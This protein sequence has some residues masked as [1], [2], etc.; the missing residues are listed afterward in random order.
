M[1]KILSPNS[2]RSNRLSQQKENADMSSRSK[3]EETRNKVRE[4]LRTAV[5]ESP[6]EYPISYMELQRQTGIDRRTVK[7]YMQD[8]IEKAQKEQELN[9]SGTTPAEKEKIAFQEK[10]EARD[11]RIEELEEKNERLL[12]KLMLVESNAQRLGIDPDE[13][14]RP[15]RRPDQS[16]SNAGR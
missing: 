9:A 8:E 7:K 10:I 15:V 5:T 3:E 12:K 13:L 6:D 4:Y 16:V 11:Q 1:K 14:Y 2:C